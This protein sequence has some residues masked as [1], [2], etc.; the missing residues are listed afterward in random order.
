VH[1]CI[2]TRHI[3]LST[4][5]D[6]SSAVFVDLRQSHYLSL[7]ATE[8]QLFKG[9]FSLP[10]V[11][12]PPPEQFRGF[13]SLA[14]DIYALGAT[15]YTT[16][17]CIEP[18]EPTLSAPASE[19]E[20]QRTYESTSSEPPSSKSTIPVYSASL[21]KIH[22]SKYLQLESERSSKFRAAQSPPSFPRAGISR[23]AADLLQAMMDADS[24][25]RPP[26]GEALRHPWVASLDGIDKIQQQ[27]RTVNL[28]MHLPLRLLGGDSY[29]AG[30]RRRRHGRRGSHSSSVSARLHACGT[31][32]LHA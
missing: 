13:A 32:T 4:P 16:T 11:Q 17:L 12:F 23:T 20:C 19:T 29:G 14:S 15:L 27:Q 24:S 18:F 5:N 28:C 7:P 30:Q 26:V 9:S 8:S 10:H 31:C 2:G 25:S 3:V 22:H 1:A 21:A 6:I